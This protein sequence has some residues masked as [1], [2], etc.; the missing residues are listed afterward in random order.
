MCSRGRGDG[1]PSC[2]EE[3]FVRIR[4]R[5]VQ[6]H[7]RVPGVTRILAQDNTAPEAAPAIIANQ[8]RGACGD[9]RR[10]LRRID[11]RAIERVR[12]SSGGLR[13]HRL[14][15]VQAGYHNVLSHFEIAA[16][17]S[18]SRDGVHGTGGAGETAKAIVELAA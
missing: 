13:R 2:D 8:H 17:S 4:R 9:Q 16:A 10:Q 15:G 12:S 14:Q 7:V 5:A 11:E 1:V 3:P 6:A 18:Y